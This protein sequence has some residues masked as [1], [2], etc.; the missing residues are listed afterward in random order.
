MQKGAGADFVSMLRS[1]KPD[2]PVIV[3]SEG[4][5]ADTAAS[6][7]AAFADK[8]SD[9]IEHDICRFLE[10]SL[11][12]GPFL[13]TSESGELLASARCIEE[14]IERLEELPLDCV[15]RHAERNDFS[16]WLIARGEIRVARILRGYTPGDF[17]SQAE[18]RDVLVRALER[19]V[20]EKSRGMIP[21][22]DARSFRGTGCMARLGGGSVGGK[23]RGILFLRRM[24]DDAAFESRLGGA[25]EID[26]PSSAFIGI[27][28]FERFL[29]ANHLWS[30]AFYDF[31]TRTEEEYLRLRE[32]FLAASL[33]SMLSER[34][35]RF[36]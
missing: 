35:R 21:A 14:M 7:G 28:S 13:F 9:S 29:A 18:A 5:G 10:E 8:N 25:L 19:A 11:R 30:Y 17:P 31:R 20:R 36:V 15:I 24:L 32:R 27:D 33:D 26:V 6:L 3:Q 1:R 12:F 23:G 16:T 4:G 22:F 34:L 2:L